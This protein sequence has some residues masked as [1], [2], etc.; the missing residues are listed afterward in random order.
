MTVL[1]AA[2]VLTLWPIGPFLSAISV[3]S[4]MLY[5]F[6][7]AVIS[8]LTEF[9]HRTRRREKALHEAAERHQAEV[10]RLLR[11]E[12]EARTAAE[13]AN[14][15]KDDFLATLSHELRTPLSVILGWVSV[16]R[17]GGLDRTQRDHAIEVIERNTQL[18]A[19]LVNDLLDVSRIVAGKLSI[20][21]EEVDL[22]RLARETIDAMHEHAAA[23]SLQ[24]RSQ[25]DPDAGWVLGDAFRLQQVISNLCSNAVKFSSAGGRID[26]ELA[27]HAAH[28]R[29]VI[30]DTGEGIDPHEIG[31][32]FERFEQAAPSASGRRQGMGLG[33]S[34]CRHIVEAHGGEIRAESKGTG[35]GAT[36]TVDL[37]V[38]SVRTGARRILFTERHDAKSPAPRLDGLCILVVDDY[39]DSREMI[40]MVLEQYGAEIRLTG[41]LREALDVFSRTRIDVVVS[42]I[43]MPQGDGYDLLACLRA[44][45][46]KD[47][48][49]PVPA[50]A[51][52]AYGSKEDREQALAAGF[53]VHLVKPVDPVRLGATIAALQAAGL[54]QAG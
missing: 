30:R 33:L 36:F 22:V 21:R 2:A 18:Q 23:K 53:Q 34:I 28:A 14:R 11:R 8:G 45:E 29:L 12:Q 19:H 37:P 52:T 27:R 35:R 3:L 26:V 1:G 48:A 9:L 17:R 20:D 42:D 51:L 46:R 32:I 16:L 39:R 49:A 4:M 43:G 44:A 5:L 40:G 50:V 54:Q 24:I 47:G 7:G 13:S 10:K 41:S 38:L 31:R 25:L 6:N 15:A